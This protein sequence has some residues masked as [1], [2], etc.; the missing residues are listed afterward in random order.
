MY[1]LIAWRDEPLRSLSWDKISRRFQTRRGGNVSDGEIKKQKENA[2]MGIE[3]GKSEGESE[4]GRGG[5]TVLMA[6]VIMSL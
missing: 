1:F 2:T 6:L 3:A 5:Y 4:V